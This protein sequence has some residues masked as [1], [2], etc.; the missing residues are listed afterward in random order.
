MGERSQIQESKR[1]S[2]HKLSG[3][4]TSS[5]NAPAS[6]Q[7]PTGAEDGLPNEEPAR[8][9]REVANTKPFQVTELGILIYM[10]LGHSNFYSNVMAIFKVLKLH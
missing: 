8:G 3:E 4:G 2:L 6:S 9:T 10:K 5:A 7:P 1:K